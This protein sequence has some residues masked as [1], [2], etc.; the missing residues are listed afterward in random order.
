M[1]ADYLARELLARNSPTMPMLTLAR[2]VE[3]SSQGTCQQKGPW[4]SLTTWV[5]AELS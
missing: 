1:F 5:P 4:F 2:Q 3:T